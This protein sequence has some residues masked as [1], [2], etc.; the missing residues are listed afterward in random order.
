MILW[1]LSFR[2]CSTIAISTRNDSP[3][4]SQRNVRPD[5]MREKIATADVQAGTVL[6]RLYK[7]GPRFSGN[8]HC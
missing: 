8:T 7:S 2:I 5:A 3:I 1:M 4:P 6:M